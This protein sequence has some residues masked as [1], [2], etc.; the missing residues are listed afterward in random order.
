MTN[1]SLPTVKRPAKISQWSSRARPASIPNYTKGKRTFVDFVDS[2]IAWWASIQPSWRTLEHGKVSHGVQGGWDILHSPRINGLLN[3]VM[4]VYWWIRI[5]EEHKPRDG[6]H[7]DYEF[8]AED[9]VWVFSQ[10]Y[11]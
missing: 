2:A 5:L 10:L 1:G 7:A 3:I 6:V 11:S 4:L 9:V 8:F